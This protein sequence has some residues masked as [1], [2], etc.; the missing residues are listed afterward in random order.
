MIIEI[1]ASNE[2][3]SRKNAGRIGFLELP[4]FSFQEVEDW[5]RLWLR[6]GFPRSYLARS[7]QASATWLKAYVST[8]LERDIPALGIQIPPQA[9]RRFWMMLAHHHG[10][11]FNASELGRSL[12]IS[13]TTARRY[14]DLLT[15]TFMMRQLS[16]WGENVSKRQVK[17]PKIHFRDLGIFHNLLGFGRPSLSAL[18]PDRRG[19]AG[20]HPGSHS[21]LK[22]GL[23]LA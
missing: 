19:W 22:R 4:P 15:G 11:V 14:L 12:G 16:P 5:R 3:I 21:V 7:D 2:E 20:G 18:R 17:T 8:F 9:L 13:D 6:G 10:Q 23:P 1:S